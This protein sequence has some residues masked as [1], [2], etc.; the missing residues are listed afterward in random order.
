MTGP[1]RRL[2]GRLRG[3]IHGSSVWM[4]D[5]HLLLVNSTRFREEYK[6]FHLRDV[7]AMAVARAPRFH[8]STR[9]AAIGAVWL[10]TLWFASLMT[11]VGGFSVV[12]YLWAIAVALVA[13]WAFISATCSCRCRIYTAVSGDDL[14]SVY[15]TW[16]ARKFLAAVEPK[17]AEVQGVL[18][19]EWA[20][21]AESRSIGPPVDAG[22]TSPMAA[23]AV[24]A[25]P[26]AAAPSAAPSHTLVSDLLVAALFAS[27]LLDF[28]TFDAAPGS[29][30]WWS[31]G[32]MALKVG[33]A[34]AVFVQHYKGKLQSGMQK[35][36][37]ATL[38][39]MG[40]MYYVEQM[41][42]GFFAGAA[43]AN[44]QA[45]AQVM[46]VIGSG[47]RLA[48]E[49]NGGASLILGCVGLGIILLAKDTEPK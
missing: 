37:I 30:R 33:L 16:T 46:P 15:R 25:A 1:Y 42:A 3:F 26:G 38:L 48:A 39:V 10:L 35:V 2:P 4:G 22:I 20:E 45:M 36:A 47:N 34:M 17:I 49:V 11:P 44:K 9:S 21:A 31:V 18:E 13:A 5:D 19:G 12:P 28:L 27:G 40:V 41:A 43:A 23:G 6:R 29:V 7:Q 14:P 32:F 24:G 8:I